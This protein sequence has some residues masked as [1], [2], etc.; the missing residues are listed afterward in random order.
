MNQIWES[1]AVRFKGTAESGAVWQAADVVCRLGVPPH[2]QM[3]TDMMSSLTE[4]NSLSSSLLSNDHSLRLRA[5]NNAF[6]PEERRDSE[7]L[8]FS[9][10]AH[11]AEVATDTSFLCLQRPFPSRREVDFCKS[12][13][14]D[15]RVVQS[16]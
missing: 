7:E 11:S 13:Q 16:E 3:N 4:H 9:R 8:E 5:L 6:A 2:V 12:D 14:N 1:L 15:C 10:I